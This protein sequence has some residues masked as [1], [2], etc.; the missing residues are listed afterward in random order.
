[1]VDFVAGSAF[2]SAF[3]ALQAAVAGLTAQMALLIQ[4]CVIVGAFLLFVMII[5][6]L[7]GQLNK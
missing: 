5:L 1:M 4:V 3:I 6:A 2:D 7:W